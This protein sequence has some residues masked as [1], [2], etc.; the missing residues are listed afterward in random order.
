M[1]C[2]I[3]SW[4]RLPH[5]VDD[6]YFFLYFLRSPSGGGGNALHQV[7][8]VAHG[9]GYSPESIS[10]AAARTATSPWFVDLWAPESILTAVAMAVTHPWSVDL[11]FPS[12]SR[13]RQGRLHRPTLRNLLPRR[14]KA[15]RSKGGS[16]SRR[17]A[18]AVP[19]GVYSVRFLIRSKDFTIYSSYW[20]LLQI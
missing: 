2:R 11:R 18:T 14:H 1:E 10:T 12:R 16:T 13:F 3:H 8:S 6:C 5:R 4:S 17:S 7:L 19:S 9:A 20:L 15:D